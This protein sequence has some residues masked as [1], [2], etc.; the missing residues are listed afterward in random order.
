MAIAV[1]NKTSGRTHVARANRP[2]GFC[3]A[4][5]IIYF[6]SFVKAKDKKK[7]VINFK[8]KSTIAKEI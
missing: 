6:F 1:E 3:L 7:L 2:E 8:N 5:L 4:R